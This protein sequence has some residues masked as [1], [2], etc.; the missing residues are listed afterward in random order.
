MAQAGA[1]VTPSP[2]PMEQATMKRLRREFPVEER[3][4]IPETATLA[5][6]KV[7]MPPSTQSGMDVKN[8]AI[9][10]DGT[11]ERFGFCP[12]ASQ[13]VWVGALT[14]HVYLKRHDTISNFRSTV[15]VRV[16]VPGCDRIIKL[17][18]PWLLSHP[19]VMTPVGATSP[20]PVRKCI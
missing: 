10:D 8:A 7:V 16:V 18:I 9:C 1:I 2:R 13:C 6:R 11:Q 3:I 17:V 20:I 5:K 12:S 4:L 15:K 14:Q 19:G